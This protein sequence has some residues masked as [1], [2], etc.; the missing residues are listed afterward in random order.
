MDVLSQVNQ[1]S[2]R[3]VFTATH[4]GVKKA[5]GGFQTS[6]MYNARKGTALHQTVATISDAEVCSIID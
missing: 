2:W 6:T 1:V 4:V 5:G 3:K